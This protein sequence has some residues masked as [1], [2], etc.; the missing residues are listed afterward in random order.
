MPASPMPMPMS[1]DPAAL[2]KLGARYAWSGLRA[3]DGGHLPSGFRAGNPTQRVKPPRMKSDGIHTRTEADIAHY[4]A[5][6]PLGTKARVAFA[7]LLYTAQQC[8]HAIRM[9][10]H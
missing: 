4:E 8:G 3:T 6:H 5:Q 10:R 9:G 1:V 2:E 7:L